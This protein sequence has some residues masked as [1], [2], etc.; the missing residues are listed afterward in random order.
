MIINFVVN[1]V[2]SGWSPK[3]KRLGGTEESVVEWASRL[4]E[5][6]HTV[7]VSGNVPKIKHRGVEY[8][9]YIGGGKDVAIKV[10]DWGRGLYLTNEVDA[11]RHDLSK[12]DAVIWPSQWAVDNIPVN[13]ETEILPHGY[14]STK[15]YPG[16][17]VPK[18]CLYASSPDRGLDT[19][20]K[21]WPSVLEKHPDA[22]LIVTYGGAGKEYSEDEMNE[23]F[24][25]SDIWIHPCNGGELFGMT[26]IK[27]QAGGCIPVYFPT[28]ALAETVQAGIKCADA[29]DMY[30][31][32]VSLLG[33]EDRKKKIRAELASKHFVDWEESTSILENIIKKYN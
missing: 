16:K 5:R 26:G 20:E 12:F 28:M 21:I 1:Q 13:T 15:I 10:P 31:Q 29:R 27:A 23:L 30:N 14:D 17:K 7:T 25:T 4:S 32:L 33:D 2:F 9:T 19:L 11:S 18:Q 8:G 3:D 22:T 6:G 24:R